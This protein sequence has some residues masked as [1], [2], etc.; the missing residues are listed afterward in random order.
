MRPFTT[1]TFW[2]LCGHSGSIT[3]QTYPAFN[4]E[5][6]VENAFSYPISINGKVRTNIE[7]ALDVEP[8][9]IEDSVLQN[10]TVQRWMEGKPAKKVI[11]VKGRIV[12][13]VI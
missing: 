2:S 5:Y 8:R 1:I 9:Q 11:V 10:E 3:K 6:L 13:V 4:E 12:N 7:F